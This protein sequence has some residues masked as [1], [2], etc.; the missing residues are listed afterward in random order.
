MLNQIRPILARLL[1]DENGGT[2]LE[3][4]LVASLLSMFI[5]WGSVRLGDVMGNTFNNI[6]SNIP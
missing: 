4:A 6:A 5:L 1:A 3:Y 2:A